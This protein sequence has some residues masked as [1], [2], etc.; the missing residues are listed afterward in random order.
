M[1]T[2][3]GKTVPSHI[4]RASGQPNER[5]ECLYWRMDQRKRKR[6]VPHVLKTSVVAAFTI[7]A[8]SLGLVSSRAGAA[9][10][11]YCGITWGS[12]AKHSGQGPGFP[13]APLTAVGAGQH[14]CFD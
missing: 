3:R 7:L 4:S 11:P 1:A 2:P 12:A 13:P 9:T 5:F 6:P 8:A 10:T 14:P